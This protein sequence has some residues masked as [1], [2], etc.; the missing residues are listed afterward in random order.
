MKILITGITGRIGTN[1]ANFLIK[2]GHDV[3]GFSWSEDQ[4]LEKIEKI[5]CKVVVGDLENYDDVRNAVS[6]NEVVLHMGAAFQS[7]GPFTPN[8]YFDINVKGTFNILEACSKN[9]NLKHL[10]VTSTDSTISKYPEKMMN[11]PIGEFDL[12]QDG[13]EWYGYSKILAENLSRRYFMAENL[14][15]TILRFSMVFGRFEVCGWSQFY[16]GHFIETINNSNVKN[17]IEIIDALTE[18][19]NN[20][21]ELI[22]P[23]KNGV[24]WKKHVIDI[25]DIVHAYDSILCNKNTF[26]STYQI[27]GPKS[28]SWE[29]VIPK[30]SKYLDLN[31]CRVELP[32][33]PTFYEFDLSSSIKDFDYSPKWDVV[34]MMKDELKSSD[35]DFGDVVPTEEDFRRGYQV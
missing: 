16:T 6:N 23:T 22:I 28:F 30:L 15:L 11:K 29:D 34:S 17:K 18:E 33:N 1:V 4:K 14:P 5:G 20:G 10:I 35:Q 32:I 25:R 8:Q 19:K 13:T 24:S 9:S 12:P 21:K 27:A 2:S 3:T 7:G 31:Y 26:G